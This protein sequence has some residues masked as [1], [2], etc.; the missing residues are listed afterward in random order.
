MHHSS[1]TRKECAWL[2]GSAADPYTLA[3]LQGYLN[4]FAPAHYSHGGREPLLYAI[5]LL[6]S[7]QPRG[8]LAFLAQA[9]PQQRTGSYTYCFVMQSIRPWQARAAAVRCS[10]CVAAQRA[11]ARPAGLSG[12]GSQWIQ[13]L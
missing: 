10:A 1:S 5:V 8:L 3:D 4:Q 2:A 9:S 13:T 11:A 6:L 7:V 12:A